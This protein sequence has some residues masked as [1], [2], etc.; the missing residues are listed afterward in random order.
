MK[1]GVIMGG[2][3]RERAISLRSGERVMAA[4]LRLGHDA[5]PLDPIHGMAW[6]RTTMDVAF[7]ALHGTM[8]EDG[9][10]QAY[11]DTLDIPYTG[12]GIKGSVLAMNKLLSKHLY[13]RH[14]IRTSPYVVLTPDQPTCPLPFPLVIKPINEGSSLGVYVVHDTPS[15][16]AA[17]TDTFQTFQACICEQYVPGTEISVG[18]LDQANGPLALPVLGLKP[19]NAF[20]DFDAKYTHGKTHFECPALLPADITQ[21]AQAMAIA[22]HVG[23]GCEGMSRSDMIVGP[24]GPVI[25]ETNTIPGLTDLS[26]L[27]AQAA[28]LGIGF[29]QLIDGLVHHAQSKGTGNG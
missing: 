21:A 16:T 14:G 3:S 28:A 15:F 7:I 25:L 29:D 12:S 13:D 10:I 2:I 11:L 5:F 1:I 26:D 4:L 9:G 24:S 19:T 6:Q 18:V 20:Y 27:P 17:L 22:A 8:G 23:L